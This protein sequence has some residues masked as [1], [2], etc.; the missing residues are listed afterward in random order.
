ME[1]S[2]TGLRNENGGCN[3]ESLRGFLRDIRKTSLALLDPVRPRGIVREAAE[4]KVE[5]SGENREARRHRRGDALG[6]HGKRDDDE[7]EG[8]ENQVL[9]G[10]HG[11]AGQESGTGAHAGEEDIRHE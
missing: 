10:E 11:S 7:R 8:G 2:S 6:N 3:K 4:E 9:E 1:D 5:C